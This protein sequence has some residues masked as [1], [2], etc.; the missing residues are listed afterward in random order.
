[1]N[2]GLIT[3]MCSTTNSIIIAAIYYSYILSIFRW[4]GLF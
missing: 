4:F 1:M 3:T 2:H